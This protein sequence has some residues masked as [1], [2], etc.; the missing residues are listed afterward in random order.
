MCGYLD[1]RLPELASDRHQTF[2]AH[3]SAWHNAD[4]GPRRRVWRRSCRHTPDPSPAPPG[5]EGF[6]RPVRYHL[7]GGTRPDVPGLEYGQRP[8]EG[9]RLPRDLATT[10]W[11]IAFRSLRR[12]MQAYVCRRT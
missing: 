3:C 8:W 10:R 2:L 12:A 11:S 1:V 4:Y 5:M 9:R 6:P 7:A